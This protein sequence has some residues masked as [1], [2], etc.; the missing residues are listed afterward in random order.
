MVVAIVGL[1]Y[2]F[3]TLLLGHLSHEVQTELVKDA[4][5]FEMPS[6]TICP[7]N[8]YANVFK[9]SPVLFS[10]MTLPDVFGILNNFW[11]VV[12]QTDEVRRK[13][14]L[15][16]VSHAYQYKQL[17]LPEDFEIFCK[18]YGTQGCNPVTFMI[19]DFSTCVKIDI[20]KTNDLP[21]FSKQFV[22]FVYYADASLENTDIILDDKD[23][24]NER[25]TFLTFNSKD[26]YPDFNTN[27]IF[28]L[29]QTL[30][31]I[32]VDIRAQEL[33]SFRNSCLSNPIKYD[34]LSYDNKI[35]QFSY[36]RNLCNMIKKQNF[37][38]EKCNCYSETL[39]IPSTNSQQKLEDLNLCHRIERGHIESLKANQSRDNILTSK[40]TMKI[41]KSSSCH[42]QYLILWK[43]DGECKPVCDTQ[44]FS[45]SS[46]NYIPWPITPMN[47]DG[48]NEIMHLIRNNTQKKMKK[49][50]VTLD[51]LI[52]SYIARGTPAMQ[53]KLASFMIRPKYPMGIKSIERESYPLS[54]FLSSFGA[55]LGLW[56]GMSI[57][58]IIEIIECLI[59]VCYI[60]YIR[61]FGYK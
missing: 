53:V 27:R 11:T 43:D 23:L 2:H 18:Y 38:F 50:N 14:R 30:V 56:I 32:F 31:N 42:D 10:N 51:K 13:S 20:T 28:G 48:D 3:V 25:K 37:I 1:G 57:I 47:F 54:N 34:V 39:P 40:E 22:W 35:I 4:V 49:Y 58:S 36:T 29:K 8:P 24:L 61:R 55:I 33:F 59:T 26:E 17:V 60:A 5:T 9:T 16:F 6:V 19:H 41:M 7:E 52:W 44:S 46:I 45:S 15:S 21:S 12:N